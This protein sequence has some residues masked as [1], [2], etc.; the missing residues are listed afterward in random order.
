MGLD[1]IWQEV[2]RFERG[3]GLHYPLLFSLV[4]GMEAVCTF[5][6]GA[7][8]STRVILDALA[9]GGGLLHSSISTDS[10][11]AVAVK[12]G[13]ADRDVRWFHRVGLTRD[14]WPLDPPTRVDLVLHD[15]AHDPDTVYKDL[16]W[17]IPVILRQGLLLVHDSLHSV[18]GLGVR[19]ALFAA[20]KE[21]GRVVT[22]LTLPYGFGLTVVS[23]TDGISRPQP[24]RQKL[25]SD[26]TTV[27]P[28]W[29]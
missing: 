15:G 13:I 1:Y 22:A 24:R 16:L 12:H 10:R 27:V 29:Q 28:Q 20:L 17:I 25:G 7:G 11:Q 4:Y 9:D 18:H 6:F 14:L 8:M 3:M 23:F 21:S 26:A 2:Y 19:A 5:E